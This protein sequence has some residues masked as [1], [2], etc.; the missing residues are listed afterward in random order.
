[1]R[2]DKILYYLGAFFEHAE[3]LTVTSSSWG[4][5]RQGKY[6]ANDHHPIG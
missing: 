5:E 1:M 2:S 3:N 6:K 4:Q